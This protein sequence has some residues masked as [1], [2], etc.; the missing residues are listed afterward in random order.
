MGAAFVSLPL[1]HLNLSTKTREGRLEKRLIRMHGA[2]ERLSLPCCVT[3]AHKQNLRSRAR[4]WF[5]PAA[6][7]P[8]GGSCLRSELFH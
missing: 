6:T 3:L 1:A 2:G 4:E 7:R 5:P 8:L